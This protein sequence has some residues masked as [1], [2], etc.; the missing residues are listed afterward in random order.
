MTSGWEEQFEREKERDSAAYETIKE[1][2][3]RD[4]LGRY[5]AIGNGRLV[6]VS[7]SFDEAFDA[8]R[9]LLHAFVFQVGEEPTSDIVYIRWRTVS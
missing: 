1:D 2:L 4:H 6:L 3:L 7:D 5:A 8:V 9:D